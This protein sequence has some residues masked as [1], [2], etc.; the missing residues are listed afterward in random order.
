MNTLHRVGA[1]C[2]AHP[3]RTLAGWLLVLLTLGGLSTVAGGDLRED[4]DVPGTRAQAGVDTLREHFPDAGGAAA[5]VVLHDDAPLDAAVVDDVVTELSQTQH[6]AGVTPR[7]S[8]DG[9]TALLQVRYAVDVT[10]PE[11]LGNTEPL[12]AAAEPAQEAGYQVELGG[13]V[14]GSAGEFDGRGEL[15][16]VGIALLLMVLAF[17]SVVAAGLPIAT[18]LGGLLAGSSGVMLLAGLTDV[19]PTAPTVAT[20]VG[21]GVGIDYALLILTRH[22]ARLRAGDTPR[23]AAARATAIAGRSVVGAGL[24]VL[25][26]LLGLRLAGLPT[27]SAFG[28]ATA[29]AVIGVMAA[30]LTLVP[31]LCALAGHRLLPRRVRRERKAGGVPITETDLAEAREPLAGRW[32]RVVARR[33]IAW[34]TLALVILV[35]LGAPALGMHTWPQDGGSDPQGSTTREAYDLVSTEFGEGTNGPITLV[36]DLDELSGEEVAALHAEV[37]ALPE[38]ALSGPAV[39]SPDGA[40]AVWDIEPTTAPIAEE[41]ATFL[42]ELRAHVLPDGV[43]ATGYTPILGDISDILAERLWIVVGF[44]VA[45]SV[46]LLMILF[47]SVV[48]P[49]KAAVMNL[50]SIA[51]AYGVLVLVFQHGYGAGLL[52]LDHAIPVSSWVPILLFAVL[53]GLSMDYEVFLLSAIRDD[54]LDTGDARGSVVR[55]LASTGRVISVAAAI[56]VAVFLGFATE[57]GVVVKMIGVGLAVAVALDA[58]VV[59]MILVP[60]TMTLLGRW[61]WW[62]PGRGF[63]HPAPCATAPDDDTDTDRTSVSV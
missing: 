40:V 38:V 54:W 62:F 57:P 18:A 32:A 46:I 33:P 5:Q 7:I 16:G 4:W 27:F 50:L 24:T 48:V 12:T 41:T 56:M 43:E 17:G 47:R 37:D 39:T 19:S 10:H 60:A 36:A 28:F 30:S 59:R 22:V 14:P 55:G 23:E 11:V 44:V 34:G 42:D 63:A 13:E 49:I 21:L 9:D 29:L 35:G 8:E 45:M 26:S 15:I 25:V 1:A 31:A 6:I 52:G 3:W 51:A 2:A 61:N 53:F 20:M 58:T